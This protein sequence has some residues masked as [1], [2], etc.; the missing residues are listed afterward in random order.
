MSIPLGCEIIILLQIPFLSSGKFQLLTHTRN[1]LV[2]NGAL[3]PSCL[4]LL[5]GPDAHRDRLETL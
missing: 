3:V 5:C 4:L 1:C 2:G